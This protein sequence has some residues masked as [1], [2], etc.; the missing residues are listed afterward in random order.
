MNG[1]EH[2]GTSA[3]GRAQWVRNHVHARP[4]L[5]ATL[6]A[7]ISF[8]IGMGAGASGPESRLGVL[9]TEL[10]SARSENAA[11]ADALEEATES[12]EAENAEL[13]AEK[14]RLEDEVQMLNARREIPN[15]VGASEGLASSL[16]DKYG[17]DLVQITRLSTKPAG[18]IL[19]QNPAPG[20]MMRYGGAYKVV[21]AKA[22]PSVPPL[23]GANLGKARKI[24]S[25][26]G[27]TVAVTE[28]ISKQRPGTVL[29]VSPGTGSRLMPGS[30]VTLTVA[31]KA[32]PPPPVA[33]TSTESSSDGCTPG[34][35]PCLPPA[36]DYDCSGGSGDGPKYTGYVTVTG[37]DP[38]DL[39]S[40]GDGAG[41]ES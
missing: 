9:E 6:A 36:S 11:A 16:E 23:R 38:Y 10:A 32:P 34:Y 20:A 24:L 22:P 18:T 8:L 12:L 15:L 14:S 29:S 19:A 39:D 30:T 4:I 37:S 3:N 40:D 25:S 26:N 28:Q 1:G 35:S 41:C 7:T 13:L 17:W 27:W 21:V 31:V 2:V 33:S 5:T